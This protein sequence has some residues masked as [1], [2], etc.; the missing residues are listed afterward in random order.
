M[1]LTPYPPV[2]CHTCAE[3]GCGTKVLTEV[4]VWA[5]P[6]YEIGDVVYT[7]GSGYFWHTAGWNRTTGE[8]HASCCLPDCPALRGWTL[9]GNADGV[10]PSG[11]VDMVQNPQGVRIVGQ[12]LDE[13]RRAY[14]HASARPTTRH[15]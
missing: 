4:D 13:L 5:Y 12:L 1:E 6:G 15:R 10:L 8:W 2:P 9:P 11:Y 7:E 3:T 14:G